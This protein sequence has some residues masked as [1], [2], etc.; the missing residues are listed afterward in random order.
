MFD[1]DPMAGDDHADNGAPVPQGTKRT[2]P[3]N[4][5]ELRARRWK[6]HLAADVGLRRCGAVALQDT[7]AAG[8]R[9]HV[10][11]AS[12]WAHGVALD[13]SRTTGRCSASVRTVLTSAVLARATERYLVASED[14]PT[15]A[16]LRAATQAGDQCSRLVARAWELARAEAAERRAQRASSGPSD[17][18]A[19]L[20]EGWAADG[21]P[22]PHGATPPGGND[23]SDTPS[24][25]AVLETD[26]PS[27]AEL[28]AQAVDASEAVG[29]LSVMVGHGLL[30]EA[31]DE[32][33][34]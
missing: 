24:H 29:E 19:L 23:G 32:G 16:T 33:E 28:E 25:N 5:A 21:Y 27:A 22:T 11:T 8:W 13:V 15:A 10:A 26:S 31:A 18:R 17:A 1:L 12:T 14:A 9:Y 34:G 7:A 20:A 3:A 4:I 30:V 2:L 6:G